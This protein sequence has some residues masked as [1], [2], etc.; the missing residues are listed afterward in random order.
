MRRD[1]LLDL[2]CMGCVFGAG[3]FTALT[4]S[5]GSGK[6]SLSISI[7]KFTDFASS[8]RNIRLQCRVH[9]SE[10]SKTYVNEE[11]AFAKWIVEKSAM[12]FLR[13][14][15]GIHGFTSRCNRLNKR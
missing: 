4:N 15:L 11:R 1:D 2:F 10:S 7:L 9:G 5:G 8:R 13:A 12:E 3:M 6:L 14:E